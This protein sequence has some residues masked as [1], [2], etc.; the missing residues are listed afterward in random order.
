LG[1]DIVN[2]N[3]KINPNQGKRDKISPNNMQNQAM[4]NM[5]NNNVNGSINGI[6]PNGKSYFYKI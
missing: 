6:H 5:K 3:G 4:K 1:N 2:N